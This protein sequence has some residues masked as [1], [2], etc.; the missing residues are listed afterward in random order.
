MDD[1][2]CTNEAWLRSRAV[3][4]TSLDNVPEVNEGRGASG[5]MSGSMK[6]IVTV[7]LIFWWCGRR[8][9]VS[10]KLH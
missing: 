7:R 9:V 4:Y 3:P 5:L 6:G 8:V 10:F 1:S 2:V